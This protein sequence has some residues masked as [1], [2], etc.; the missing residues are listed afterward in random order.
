MHA[1][2]GTKLF[3]HAVSGTKLFVLAIHDGG[4][5]V[6]AVCDGGRVV[7]TVRGRSRVLD[8]VRDGRRSNAMFCLSDAAVADEYHFFTVRTFV[9]RVFGNVSEAFNCDKFNFI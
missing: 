1:V 7:H 4:R 6:H 5:V 2:S 9:F 3:V 8:A